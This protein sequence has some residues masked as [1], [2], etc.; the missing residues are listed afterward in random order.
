[1]SY[2]YIDPL[3]YAPEEMIP[4][5][6]IVLLVGIVR[7]GEFNYY[8]LPRH[9]VYL[10]AAKGDGAALYDG[11][12]GRYGIMTVDE[13]HED[14]FFRAIE[15]HKRSLERLKEELYM[16]MNKYERAG[17]FIDVIIDFD[18]KHLSS[19]FGEP[20]FFEDSVPDGWTS[21]REGLIVPGGYFFVDDG[22]DGLPPES[23]D[24]IGP[25]RYYIPLDKRFWIDENGKSLFELLYL[26]ENGE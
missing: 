13:A 12:E 15:P 25:G 9:L 22:P 18:R 16:C 6:I 10:D 11:I 24:T 21:A 8:V 19:Y 26:K 17:Y 14:K 23:M 3:D 4:D 1:M 20:Y 5:G 2:D 7:H